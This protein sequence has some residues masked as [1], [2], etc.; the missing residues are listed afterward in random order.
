[1]DSAG[2][3]RGGTVTWGH[4]TA[5]CIFIST[6][7]CVPHCGPMGEVGPRLVSGFLCPGFTSRISSEYG[8]QP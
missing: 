7:S 4:R 8:P 6:V 1:M 2:G 5:V 3:V